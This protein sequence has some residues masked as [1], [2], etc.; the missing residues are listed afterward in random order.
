MKS[1]QFYV[2]F[3]NFVLF[4]PSWSVNLRKKSKQTLEALI[5]FLETELSDRVF[6]VIETF[7][8]N[9]GLF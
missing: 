1:I 4:W 6:A 5:F 3:E 2:L 9:T 8:S 7:L